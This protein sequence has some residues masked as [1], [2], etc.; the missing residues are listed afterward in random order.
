MIHSRPSE[1]NIE[2][3]STYKTGNVL[4]LLHEIRHAMR[5]WL[6]DGEKTIID[7]RAMPMAP[8]EEDLIIEELGKGEVQARLIALGLSEIY[9][10]RFEG[11]WLVTHYNTENEIIGRYI[12]ITDMPELLKSQQEDVFV[13]LKKL[14]IQLEAES[15]V[16]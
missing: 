16:E 1:F 11:V 5:S 3:K 13:S 2:V 15:S 10:T 7:L 14:E 9:E 8:G 4:P 6:N 12:E